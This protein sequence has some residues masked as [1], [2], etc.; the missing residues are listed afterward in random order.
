MIKN[1]KRERIDHR[2]GKEYFNQF[3]ITQKQRIVLEILMCLALLNKMMLLNAK[4]DISQR[5]LGCDLFN[6][7][8]LNP[9]LEVVVLN[10]A[11]L[12][13][14]LSSRVMGNQSA[15]GMLS[16]FYPKIVHSSCLSLKV[17]CCTPYVHIHKQHSTKLDPR[18]IEGNWLFKLSK[19]AQMLLSFQP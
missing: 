17:F 19:I 14:R 1:I 18:A 6:L 9:S 3:L 8:F 13:N 2:M 11:Y 16:H 4:I 10:T 15:L 5:L 7:M 12:I